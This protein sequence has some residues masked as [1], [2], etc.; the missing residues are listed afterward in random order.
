MIRGGINHSTWQNCRSDHSNRFIRS[1]GRIKF[2]TA[3][4]KP[5]RMLQAILLFLRNDYWDN[6]DSN[7][8]DDADNQ[9]YSHLHILPPHLFSYSVGTTP[10]ALRGVRQVICLILE[11]IQVLASFC[12][13]V[14]VVSHNT[15]GVVDLSLNL[16]CSAGAVAALLLSTTIARD[17]WIVLFRH[18]FWML[19][20]ERDGR[21]V[22]VAKVAKVARRRREV[23]RIGWSRSEEEE[24]EA[25]VKF[26]LLELLVLLL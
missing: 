12:G 1:Y 14:D 23:F 16:S 11:L 7:E 21:G 22:V 24:E 6:D 2:F 4:Q 9:A 19:C 15:N 17:I 5:M 8:D 18:F 25:T 26:T 10:K 13:L 20:G 3:F